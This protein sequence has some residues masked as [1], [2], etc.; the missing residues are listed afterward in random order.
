MQCREPHH[1]YAS[2]ADRSHLPGATP[3]LVRRRGP[4]GDRGTARRARATRCAGTLTSAPRTER[5]DHLAAEGTRS[6]YICTTSTPGPR[7]RHADSRQ[8]GSAR[9]RSCWTCDAARSLRRCS[10]KRRSSHAPS[11]SARGQLAKLTAPVFLVHGAADTIIPRIETLWLA[12]EFPAGVEREVLVS[13]LLR[14]AEIDQPPTLRETW[15]LVSF[16][17]DVLR[18]SAAERFTR[19]RIGLAR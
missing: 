18:A 6:I 5:P 17:A 9:W 15:Q 2:A 4:A 8:T 1:D 16:M 13:P 7:R 10:T 3:P 19:P 14:H 12:E 11:C